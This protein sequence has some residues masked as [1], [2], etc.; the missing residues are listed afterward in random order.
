MEQGIG[1]RGRQPPRK[2]VVTE[3]D[4]AEVVAMWTGIP[5]TRIASEESERLLHMEEALRGQ[6]HRSGRGDHRDH[7]SRSAALAPA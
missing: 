3:D 7:A 5:V 4:I 1:R 6:G 2:P